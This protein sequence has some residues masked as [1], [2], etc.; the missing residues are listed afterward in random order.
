LIFKISSHEKEWHENALFIKGLT[1]NSPM[2]CARPKRKVSTGKKE[3]PMVLGGR[4]CFTVSHH[5]IAT[6]E[7]HQVTISFAF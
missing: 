5:G 2:S 4:I 6:R 7:D 3:N 1:L